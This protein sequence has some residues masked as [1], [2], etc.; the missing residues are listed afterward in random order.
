MLS[1]KI[2]IHNTSIGMP[3][4][5]AET[6]TTNSVTLFNNSAKRKLA[7]AGAVLFK[8]KESS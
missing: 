8:G 6:G 7:F 4:I 3:M 2:E 5:A 1:K